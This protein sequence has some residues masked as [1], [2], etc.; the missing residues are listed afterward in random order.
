MA[1]PMKRKSRPNYFQ[2]N[3]TQFGEDFPTRKS[4]LEIQKDAKNIFNDIA[5][6]NIDVERDAK[7]FTYTNFLS[8]LILVAQD[9][10][11]YH[12]Y[13]AEGLKQIINQSGATRI[14]DDQQPMMKVID[15][16]MYS[17]NAYNVI[18]YYLTNMLNNQGVIVNLAEL[19]RQLQNFRGAFS[20]VYIIRDDDA[21]R[22]E[23]RTY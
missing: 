12:F 16:H 2:M 10:Y 5:Y 14:S 11:S 18:I 17:A 19:C 7:C 4:P 22:R 1:K 9:N 20:D 8:N 15:K 6:G 13:S 3:V 21:R 23:R